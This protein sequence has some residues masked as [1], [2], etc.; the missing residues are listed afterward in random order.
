MTRRLHLIFNYAFAS[1][2]TVR[3]RVPV[4]L[5]FVLLTFTFFL[6][7][8]WY[9]PPGR[10]VIIYNF[11]AF[12]PLAVL[13]FGQWWRVLTAP[14]VHYDIYHLLTSAAV[15]AVCGTWF[16]LKHGKGPVAF[17]LAISVLIPMLAVSVLYGF[18][19][20]SDSLIFGS[21]YSAIALLGAAAWPLNKMIRRTNGYLAAA[22]LLL[23]CATAYLLW[24][25]HW[26]FLSFQGHA[27]ALLAGLAV[28]ALRSHFAR[29]RFGGAIFGAPT[30]R[31]A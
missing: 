28:S 10:I 21:S 25:R 3:R 2:A 12:S 26:P 31:S 24:Q 29:W 7:Q 6:F 27:V 9:G 23:G 15:I 5:L 18:G 16:E 8:I 1:A 4:S 14:F 30:G 11:G 13:T 22:G 17:L 20:P 19:L